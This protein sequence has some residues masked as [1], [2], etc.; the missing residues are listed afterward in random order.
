M[1]TNEVQFVNKVKFSP[2]KWFFVKKFGRPYS[3]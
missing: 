1:I 3:F 2:M